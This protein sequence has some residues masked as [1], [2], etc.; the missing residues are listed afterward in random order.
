MSGALI[1]ELPDRF[2]S[3]RIGRNVR[4]TWKIRWIQ[5]VSEVKTQWP[6]GC[7]VAYPQSDGLRVV[8]VIAAEVRVV[9]KTELLVGLVKA[10]QAGEHFLRPRIDVAHV[11]KN[12]EAD[13]VVNERDI[14]IGK[15][16]FEI[17]DE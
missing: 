9:V 8:V 11:F 13:A 16:H 2:P 15:T 17:V 12:G 14:D 3:R 10:Y 4:K 1:A 7:L 5:I 6:D